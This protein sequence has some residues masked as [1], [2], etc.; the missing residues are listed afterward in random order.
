MCKI[1]LQ[2]VVIYSFALSRQNQ[3][4]DT[5]DAE[6]SETDRQRQRSVGETGETTGRRHTHTQAHTHLLH[7]RPHESDWLMGLK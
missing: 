2:Y 7:L 1:F 4:A 6:H 3:G 5:G